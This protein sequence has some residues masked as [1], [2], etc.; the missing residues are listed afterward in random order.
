MYLLPHMPYEGCYHSHFLNSSS[1]W[2]CSVWLAA[3]CI[4]IGLE[5][6]YKFWMDLHPFS[7]VSE[8]FFRDKAN[9]KTIQQ[10]KTSSDMLDLASQKWYSKT[11]RFP[12]HH[13]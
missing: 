5:E 12:F 10:G 7:F 3:V 11:A 8:T 2:A 13:H 6:M 9:I 1:K 4:F